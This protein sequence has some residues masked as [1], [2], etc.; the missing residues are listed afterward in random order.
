MAVPHTRAGKELEAP[1]SAILA[2]REAVPLE[3]RAIDRPDLLDWYR[4]QG[5]L[6]RW[7][8]L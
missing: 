5:R 7:P 4:E 6:H 8:A 2:G 1:V 3:P